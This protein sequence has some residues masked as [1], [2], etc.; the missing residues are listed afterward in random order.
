MR[1]NPAVW[2][3]MSMLLLP[4]NASAQRGLLD[5]AEA[6]ITA[7]VLPDARQ[8]LQRW[9]R[10]NPT[11]ART[12]EENQARFH[13]LTARVNADAQVAED[14]YLTVAVNY[15]TTRVA[16]EA[17]L[18]LG[19][20]RHARG[21]SQHAVAYLERVMADYPESELRAMAAIW[22]ARVQTGTASKRE[23]CNVLR[24]VET[25]SNPETIQHMKNE[26]I[27]ACGSAQVVT[28]ARKP[29]APR[30]VRTD[31]IRAPAKVDTAVIEP[32]EPASVSTG[33]STIAIQVGAYRELSRARAAKLELERAGFTGAR[34]VRVPG[35]TLIRVRIGKFNN[36]AA[37]SA[38][39]A[40]LG[41][42]NLSAVLVNDTESETAVRN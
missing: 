17:L 15:P 40:R 2:L 38:L 9:R 29:A 5:E 4:A 32:A 13:V 12:D 19:Q 10:E 26:Q 36:R 39:L 11:A 16:P 34:L 41:A 21:D 20:A 7:G 24:S 3:C 42:A 25:G 22:L 6:L 27:R 37:A 33:K 18:R 23:L 30:S 31:T 14:H 1:T 8:A 28:T 35:N